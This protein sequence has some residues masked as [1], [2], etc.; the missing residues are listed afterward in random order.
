MKNMFIKKALFVS[1]TLRFV[2][3]SID[4]MFIFFLRFLS[5]HRK[6]IDED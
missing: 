2:K 1:E 6:K 3:A 4:E 5:F